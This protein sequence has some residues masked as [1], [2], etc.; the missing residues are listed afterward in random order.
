[1]SNRELCPHCGYYCTG[2]T[3]FCTPPIEREDMKTTEEEF[4]ENRRLHRWIDRADLEDIIKLVAG[5]AVMCLILYG[6]R[7]G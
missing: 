1:M 4:A 2:K 6:L 5:L 3:V 7:Y